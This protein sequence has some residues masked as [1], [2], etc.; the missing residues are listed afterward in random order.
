[1]PAVRPAG[2]ASRADSLA[3]VPDK[4]LGVDACRTGW[5]GVVPDPGRTAAFFA[6]TIAELVAAADVGGEVAVVAIDMPIG[7]ADSGRRRADLQARQAAGARRSSVFLTPVRAALQAP[8]H[9]TAV[10]VNQELAG[11]GISIQAF[12]L[13][14]KV[15]E[16]DTWVRIQTRRVVEVHPEVSFAEMAGTPLSGSKVTWAGVEQRRGLLAAAGIRLAGELGLAGGA[17]RVDDVLDAA[18]AAWTARRVAAGVA[19]SL[20][21]PP[22]RYGDGLPCAIWV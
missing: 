14:S 10:R 12:S 7:L 17:A 19:K 6:R 2:V 13:R 3:P 4:V 18:A 21:D 16:V 1:V 11:E 5:V 15:L 8:D 20:P 9:A 22:D